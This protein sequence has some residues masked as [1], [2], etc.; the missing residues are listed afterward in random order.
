MIGY[1][2]SYGTN[3]LNQDEKFMIFSLNPIS[4]DSELN[5]AYASSL[6]VQIIAESAE[7]NLGDSFSYQFCDHISQ[8][9]G[10]FQH[11]PETKTLVLDYNGFCK[12]V[13]ESDAIL[14]AISTD[15]GMTKGS[16]IEQAQNFFKD[17]QVV[18]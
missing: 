4:E 6:P 9:C 2:Y 5:L 17:K 14:N 1:P 12:F 10:T 15:L 13:Y 16:A 8:I 18:V 7:F 11:I 3:N